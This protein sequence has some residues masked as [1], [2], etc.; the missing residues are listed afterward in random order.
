MTTDKI[1]EVVAIYSTHLHSQGFS[2]ERHS[3]SARCHL[4]WMCE[5]GIPGLVREGRIEKAMRW[6][7]FVQG[8][9][10]AMGEYSIEKLREHNRNQDEG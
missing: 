2:P 3:L 10:W 7:G 8:A 1:L 4:L 9:L 6:L 5:E